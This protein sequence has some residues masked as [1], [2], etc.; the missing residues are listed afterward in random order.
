MAFRY[1]HLGFKYDPELITEYDGRGR[2]ENRKIYHY[3]YS[4]YGEVSGIDVLMGPWSPYED[5]TEDQFQNFVE[6]KVYGWDE[7]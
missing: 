2:P 5:I 7:A 4:S 6:E 1:E 3:I